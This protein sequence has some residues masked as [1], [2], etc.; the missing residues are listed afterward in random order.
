MKKEDLLTAY[1]PECIFQRQVLEQH[2]AFQGK[3]SLL[4]HS[5]NPIFK[6]PSFD[7]FQTRASLTIGKPEAGQNITT[8]G[9]E[10]DGAFTQALDLNTTNDTNILGEDDD[11]FGGMTS[12]NQKSLEIKNESFTQLARNEVNALGARFQ[13]LQLLNLSMNKIQRIDASLTAACPNLVKLFLSDNLLKQI[14]P[15]MFTAPRGSRE[16]A[17]RLQVLDLSINQ[18]NCIEN[19]QQ[20]G[21]LEELNLRQNQISVVEGLS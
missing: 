14:H 3:P 19:L 20:L 15:L 1:S 11:A 9:E 6:P 18:I 17:C 13:G 12:S 16:G 5:N 7:Y 10:A 8:E 4:T 2:E 21:N